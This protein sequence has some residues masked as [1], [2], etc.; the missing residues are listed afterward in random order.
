MKRAILILELEK[1]QIA[2]ECERCKNK[3]DEDFYHNWISELDLAIKI[4]KTVREHDKYPAYAS[5]SH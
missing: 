2:H 4:L 5:L 1:N 3:D